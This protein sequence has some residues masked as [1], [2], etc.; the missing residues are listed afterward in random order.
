MG[1]Y[2]DF[3]L[4]CKVNPA[5]FVQSV[6]SGNESV[7]HP[8]FSKEH[9]HHIMSDAKIKNGTLTICTEIKNYDKEIETFLDWLRPYMVHTFN[10]IGY[11]IYE[12]EYIPTPI[13]GTPPG[14]RCG[15]N[16]ECLPPVD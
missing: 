3:R 5:F 6:L 15:I 2:T 1:M 16:I 14:I 7:T 11:Y 9:S 13:F 12:N 10:I 4:K 8:F